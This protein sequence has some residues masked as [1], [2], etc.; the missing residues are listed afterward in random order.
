MNDEVKN[1]S[2]E[3]LKTNEGL[4]FHGK[5]SKREKHLIFQLMNEC[6]GV[7]LSSVKEVI[8]LTEITAI[9]QVPE[10]FKG[11]INLRGRIISVI[12]LRA[13]FKMP[14][15]SYEPKKTCIIIAEIKDLVIGAIVDDVQQVAGFMSDQI[16]SGLDIQSSVNRE[17]I[18]GVAKTDNKKLIVL[19]DIGKVLNAEDLILMRQQQKAS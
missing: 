1:V 19:L 9:P 14:L 2:D 4:K 18:T 11:L 17:S 5:E 13:K 16:E 6:Y 8:G 15:S 12:D 3:R 7:P 10:Y